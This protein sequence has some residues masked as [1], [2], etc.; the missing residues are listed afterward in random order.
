MIVSPGAWVANGCPFFVRSLLLA[1]E[2]AHSISNLCGKIQFF[3]LQCTVDLSS[4]SLSHYLAP[5]TSALMPDVDAYLGVLH[6]VSCH[7]GTILT[8]APV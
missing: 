5:L 7:S 8:H 4:R 2:P 1:Q 3:L 6:L